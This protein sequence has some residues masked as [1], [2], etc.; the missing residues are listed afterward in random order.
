MNTKNHKNWEEIK[1]L[2]GYTPGKYPRIINLKPTKVTWI[3]ESIFIF[4][5]I[6]PAFILLLLLY[7]SNRD[8]SL[9][10]PLFILGGMCVLIMLH[11]WKL[12]SVI[13]KC[14][15]K[16]RQMKLRK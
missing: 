14:S 5:F 3:I 1:R 9:V 2:R 8:T 12:K 13:W 7:V 4:L 11:L 10:M 16:E 15:K 6:F